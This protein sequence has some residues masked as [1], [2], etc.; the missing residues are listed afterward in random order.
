MKR[1]VVGLSGASGSIIFKRLV[2][3]LIKQEV[4]VYTIATKNAERVF[5]YETDLNYREFLFNINSPHLH[6]CDIDDFFSKVASGSFKTDGMIIAPC[7]LGTI[8][9]I[10]NGTSDN[11]MIRAADVTIKE[12]RK[13]LFVPREAPLSAIHLENLLKL[14]RLGVCILPP[15]PAFYTKPKT[16]DDIINQ[17]IGRILC[18]FD[19]KSD[20]IK[21]WEGQ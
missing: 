21:P 20:L 7:S 10:A 5:E 13:T 16:V 14:A 4:E 15:V 12:H 9:K 6:M 3:E 1:I 2:E 8:G 19:L 11:L 18:Y 17:I